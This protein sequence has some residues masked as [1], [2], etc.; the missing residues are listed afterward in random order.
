MH[1]VMVREERKRTKRPIQLDWDALLHNKE[2]DAPVELVV[3]TASNTASST[4]QS[5]NSW[6]AGFDRQFSSG[7]SVELMDDHSL[8]EAILSKKRTLE[9]TGRKLPDKG[10]KLQVAIKRLEEEWERRK[11]RRHEKEDDNNENPRQAARSSTVGMPKGLKEESMSSQARSQSSSFVTLFYKKMEEA[12]RPRMKDHCKELSVLNHCNKQNR[13]NNRELSENG[14]KKDQPS[15]RTLPFQC[16]SNLSKR[17]LSND[18]KRKHASQ[19][20]QTDDS[21]SRKGDPIVLDVEDEFHPLEEKEQEDK[22]AD[23]LKKAKIYYPSSND[24]EA[25]EIYYTDIECL[26]PERYLTCTIMNFYI[27]YLQQQASTTNRSIPDYHFFNTYFYNKLKEAVS[28]K[29]SERETFFLTF[30]RWWKG[31]NIFQKSYLLIPIHED[32]HWS[33]VI[34]C[35][36]DKEDD[37]GPIILHLDSLGFH[38]SAPVFNKIRSFLREEWSY[39][40]RECQSSDIPISSKIWKNLPR[41]IDDKIVPVPQQMNDYDCGV[42]VLYFIERFIEDAPQ[43]LKKEDLAMFGKK[44]F[45]PEEASNLRGKIRKLLSEEFENSLKDDCVLKSSPLQSPELECVE[46]STSDS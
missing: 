46:T 7:D 22:L 37:T 30:R 23:C 12:T 40:D 28:C 26:A 35:I 43:R 5:Q 4:S 39:L 44:W 10:E 31:V 33:L 2:D 19:E 29:Q 41:R 25:I 32:L 8:V 11:K 24:A 45:K 20:I 36:P 18:G 6:T 27:R 34:I 13:T 14:R 9:N 21:R 16:P 3:E 38:S 17:Y 42:F 15:S 1:V